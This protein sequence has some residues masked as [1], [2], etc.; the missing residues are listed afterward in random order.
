M[1]TKAG[2]SPRH[3]VCK[4]EL[5]GRPAPTARELNGC[6]GTI[7]DA[8]IEVHKTVG[9]GL[10]EKAYLACLMHELQRRGLTIERQVKLSLKYKD[11]SVP[12]A[13]YPDLIVNKSV[14]VEVKAWK[15]GSIH[16]VR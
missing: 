2:V 5:H 10:F 4:C 11:L 15:P 1:P 9:P 6:T 7:I 13:Y 8:A 3:L 12:G 14:I 16:N